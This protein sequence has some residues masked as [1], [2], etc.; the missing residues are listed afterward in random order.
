MRVVFVRTRRENRTVTGGRG[1]RRKRKN[2]HEINFGVTAAKTTS[3]T[4]IYQHRHYRNNS[5]S[6][7]SISNI[8]FFFLFSSSI[9][10]NS[11]NAHISLGFD[12]SR[13][14]TAL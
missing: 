6:S 4:T 13:L 12:S 14:M 10:N 8:S 2:Y 3:A 7:R 1:E 5:S 11:S 9:N